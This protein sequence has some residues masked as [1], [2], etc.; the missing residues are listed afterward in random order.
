MREK[1]WNF[2][3]RGKSAAWTAIFTGVLTAFTYMM[4]QVSNTTSEIQRSSERA[5]L[6]FA[7][8]ENGARMVNGNF[9]APDAPWTSQEV[10]LVWANNGET[11]ARS[12]VVKVGSNAFYPDIPEQFDFPL[13]DSK[14]YMVVGPKSAYGT[15]ILIP[16][17]E[18]VDVWHVKKRLFVWGTAV[19]RDVFPKSPDRLTEFCVELTH[20]TVGF[21]P[22]S[23][24]TSTI[25]QPNAKDAPPPAAAPPQNVDSPQ[26]F[27]Q[28]FQSQQCRA[29]NC[30][31]ED[32]PD[33][34]D[35]VKE[36][37]Q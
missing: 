26:A 35:R 3:F 6:T 21:I 15:N 30:Y 31:D 16:K 22:P 29:H 24:P 13:N 27:L 9:L 11:P 4:Y 5:F 28:G 19:Y 36:I 37:H 17:D 12:A 2:L 1:I 32:C 33:Y 10:A 23:P 7:G 34:K 18:I 20:L 8:P 14:I 25:V